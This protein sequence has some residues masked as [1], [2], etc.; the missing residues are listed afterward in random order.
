MR[1]IE[2]TVKFV[3]EN[4]RQILQ[5]FGLE[6]GKE[7]SGAERWARSGGEIE[8]C[9][10]PDIVR[11]GE[12]LGG[13]GV[14]IPDFEL[15]WINL[16]RKHNP[17]YNGFSPLLGAYITNFQEFI[18]PPTIDERDEDALV[19][20]RTWLKKI[21]VFMDKF[22]S[23]FDELFA[24]LRQGQLGPI[25][26]RIGWGHQVKWQVFIHWLEENNI[27]YPPELVEI[28]PSKRIDPFEP[29]FRELNN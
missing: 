19:Q 15:F 26:D 5:E 13:V 2:L 9:F 27:K 16:V 10:W 28:N 29:I 3:R 24:Q 14:N 20:E 18:A 23:S 22:P 11:R 6:R 17:K 12:I 1:W 4:L 21:V 25:R 8:P 7:V